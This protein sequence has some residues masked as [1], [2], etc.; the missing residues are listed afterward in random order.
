MASLHKGFVRHPKFT[1]LSDGAFRLWAAGWSYC[2]EQ[3]TD[4]VIHK[5]TLSSLGVRVRHAWIAELCT[6]VPP[7]RYSLWE[8]RGET[9][10]MHDYLDWNDSRE[11][12][13]AGRAG[14]RRRVK[15][16]R[17]RRQQHVEH[18][19]ADL[20]SIAT[21]PTVTPPSVTAPVTPAVTPLVTPP[22]T[23]PVTG[24]DLN[25]VQRPTSNDPRTGGIPLARAREPAD[26][27]G[28]AYESFRAR[29][30]ELGRGTLPLTPRAY[31]AQAAIDFVTRYPDPTQQTQLVEAYLAS[32]HRPLR[33]APITMGQLAK[34][35]AWL[36][37][38]QR[39]PPAE[40]DEEFIRKCEERVGILR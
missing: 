2:Q 33:A 30:A 40:S 26:A 28:A 17:T 29:A 22:V 38:N 11:E 14:L 15:E 13:Q 35:A 32:T 39:A 10:L 27:A 21:A 8:E 5:N 3:L 34:W 37:D 18:P 20:F 4:G 24:R 12:V 31:E 16:S 6:V 19:A 25:N 1:A 23:P 7:Y 9:Y 36:E